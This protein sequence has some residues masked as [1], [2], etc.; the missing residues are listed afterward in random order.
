[1]R[2]DGRVAASGVIGAV[3][4]DRD[5]GLI[6]GDLRQQIGQRLAIPAGIARDLDRSDIE[7]FRIDA[8]VD[9]VPLAAVKN[10]VFP[11]FPSPITDHLDP[12][13]VDQQV[14]ASRAGAR[15][16]IDRQTLLAPAQRRIIRRQPVQTRQPE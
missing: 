3:A 6:L 16:Q 13:A 7:G 4:V 15:A 5:N 12:G 11:R 1:M 10:L 8:D 2:I 9:L 14:Q